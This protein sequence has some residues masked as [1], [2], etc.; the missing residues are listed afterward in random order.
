LN[1]STV[2][3]DLFNE[4]DKPNIHVKSLHKG[5]LKIQKIEFKQYQEVPEENF[6]Y[7]WLNEYTS[8]DTNGIQPERL[9]NYSSNDLKHLK[10]YAISKITE[11]TTPEFLQQ[12]SHSPQKE[13]TIEAPPPII[14]K[15]LRPWNGTSLEAKYEGICHICKKRI[16]IGEDITWLKRE[17]DKTQWIHRKCLRNGLSNQKISKKEKTKYCIYCGN[18]MSEEQIFCIQCGRSRK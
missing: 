9:S 6:R 1:T 3:L 8:P 5:V 14:E 10:Q 11:R 17:T 13:K 16:K 18:Q 7:S 2:V 4:L 12:P 15:E